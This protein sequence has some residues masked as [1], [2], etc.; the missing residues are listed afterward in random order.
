M[1]RFSCYIPCVTL[2][3]LLLA[4]LL[5]PFVSAAPATTPGATVPPV[6]QACSHATN[7]EAA[8]SCTFL[9]NDSAD[10]PDGP[11]YTVRC[12]DNSKTQFNQ[13]IASW[14]WDFGD[15]GSST[16]QNPR[17]TY[18]EASRYDIQLSVTTFCGP[19]YTNGTMNSI[20]IY[21][22]APQPAFTTN[23]TEGYA[24]LSVAVTDTSLRTR[25]DM[26]RWTYWFD[27]T[28]S[29]TERNPVF[30]YTQPGTYLINQTVWKDCV[31]LG[32]SL[33]PPATRQIKVNPPSSETAQVNVTKTPPAVSS[34]SSPITPAAT[35]AVPVTAA[36][37]V[38]P[39]TEIPPG[40]GTI[41]V[42]TEPAG[43]QVFVDDVLKGT[44]PVTITDLSAGSHTVRFEKEGYHSM[45]ASVAIS[46]GKTTEF[47]TSL[48]S[49][50]STGIALLPVIA[51]LFIVLSVLVAGAYLYLKQRY[52]NMED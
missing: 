38:P 51:L 46:G 28:H 36:V 37:T 19:Q 4:A 30:T 26:T 32:S 35:Q 33:Y 50:G 10:I 49:T 42:N 7:P 16:D 43:V 23:I 25:E 24:P 29:S 12:T 13:S 14:R 48:I 11:P 39:T 1:K 52:E 41:S 44:S 15:G 17:H 40:T 45:T 5:V 8:F 21:C 2:S 22:S 31:Q 27:N 47:S 18:S 20:S 9:G 34:P 6:L 3:V